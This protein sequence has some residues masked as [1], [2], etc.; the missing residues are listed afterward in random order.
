MA[1]SRVR[2]DINSLHVRKEP[3]DSCDKCRRARVPLR[4]INPAAE[5]AA[6]D[7]QNADSGQTF[8]LRLRIRQVLYFWEMYVPP[9]R[10]SLREARGEF[11]AL[12]SRKSQKQKENWERVKNEEPEGFICKMTCR[13]L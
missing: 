6:D 2:F 10:P 7:I 4:K 5:V 9:V 3:F 11:D 1:Q 8:Y 13:R 12:T